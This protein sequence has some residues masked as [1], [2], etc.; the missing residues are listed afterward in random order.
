MVKDEPSRWD[1]SRHYLDADVARTYDEQRFS[2]L[3]GRVFNHLERETVRWAFNGL[4]KDSLVADIPCGT[5]RLAAVLLESGY[6][7][8]GMDISPAMLDQASRRLHRFGDRFKTRVVDAKELGQAEREFDAA[9]CARVLMHYPLGDQIDFLQGVA[10]I[11]RTR[12]VFN[13]SV[14]NRYNRARR[15]LKKLLHHQTSVA[16]PLSAAEISKLISES[17]LEE[18]TRKSILP[19]VSEGKFFVCRHKVTPA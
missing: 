13:Q 11:T 10:N 16:H 1:P 14:N 2:S 19:L 12:V 8:V 7:V 9:L 4:P 5:G 17:G 3:A 18:V 15:K 6:R